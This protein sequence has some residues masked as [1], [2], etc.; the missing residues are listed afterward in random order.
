MVGWEQGRWR[1]VLGFHIGIGM[2][3]RE[4]KERAVKDDLLGF[5]FMQF[6]IWELGFPFALF[7]GQVG[8]YV[9][10]H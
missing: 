2:G 4:A 5:W 8:V 7:N 9:C 6:N 1:E 3:A 10:K